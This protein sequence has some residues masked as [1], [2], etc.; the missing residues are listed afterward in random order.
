MSELE[1]EPSA[2]S[3]ENTEALAVSRENAEESAESRE[4]T[5]GLAEDTSEEYTPKSRFEKA[6]LAVYRDDGLGA[7]LKI[8]SYT[9][10]LATLYAFFYRAVLLFADRKYTELA[11]LLCCLAVSFVTVTVA[12]KFIDAKR[13][14][15]L[16]PFYKEAPRKK[17]GRSFPSRHTFSIFAIGTALCYFD[18]VL[19]L[20]L[21]ALGVLLAVCRVLLGYHFIRDTV[22]G[23]LIGAVSGG[24][25]VLFLSLI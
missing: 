4:N 25:T 17:K 23:A 22:A 6:L 12:R 15:E 3:R 14:Y 9:A 19:G 8:A 18:L 11:L 10:V 24:L 13:P 20:I 16:L 5:E 2:V 7:I 1:F 21:V